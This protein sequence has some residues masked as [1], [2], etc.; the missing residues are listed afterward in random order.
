MKH[1]YVILMT[2]ACRGFAKLRSIQRVTLSI[3]GTSFFLSGFCSGQMNPPPNNLSAEFPSRAG[4]PIPN[5]DLPSQVLA[6]NGQLTLFA[7][8]INCSKDGCPLYL[9]NRT[10][11]D[12]TIPTQDGRLFVKLTCETSSGWE[13]A[14][15]HYFSDCGNSYYPVAL[16]PGQH[17][18]T[19]GYLA[20][21]GNLGKVRYQFHAGPG[22]VS[23]TG[24]G[25]W[26][27]E[28]RVISNADQLAVSGGREL[29]LLSAEKIAGDGADPWESVENSIA[30]LD[31]VSQW[32]AQDFLHDQLRKV[33]ESTERLAA[34]DPEKGKRSLAKIEE[35]SKRRPKP[36]AP[37]DVLRKACIDSIKSN[38]Q[39]DKSSG[40]A[41]GRPWIAW[42]VLRWLIGVEI[43]EKT[44]FIP[45]WKDA[46]N[47]AVERL[48]LAGWR[49]KSAIAELFQNSPL[50]AEHVR[51][52]VLVTNAKSEAYWLS[53]A[54]IAQLAY[55]RAYQKMAGIGLGA[56]PAL[57]LRILARF[58]VEPGATD[59]PRRLR[60]SI[61]DPTEKKFWE[62]CVQA[63]PWGSTFVMNSAT[64]FNERLYLEPWLS[65]LLRDALIEL[66]GAAEKGPF[67]AMSL[68]QLAGVRA[69]MKIMM[70]DPGAPSIALLKRVV[71]LK[72]TTYGNDPKE[73][74]K[75]RQE[76]V[77]AAGRELR[78]EEYFR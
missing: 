13:R 38:G 64:G 3:L 60:S 8:F 11:K 52:E 18:R 29:D 68:E 70:R 30:Y 40:S 17:F 4:E 59:I 63:D 37:A 33:K 7:D 44:L 36:A 19:V 48:P 47:L 61:Y 78:M 20:K 35:I 6:E 2:N 26:S 71:Q 5:V 15:S 69:Y 49:E 56:D 57:R 34:T 65:L 53:E 22:V 16:S 41:A 73:N 77:Q 67:P 66:I 55:R 54:C 10:E 42:Y 32:R 9:V 62:S 74:A 24:A 27:E 12:I 1:Y 75:G 43:S 58:C 45:A 39:G 21:S 23:N 50:M 14:Q 25:Y 72:N 51:T 76:V 28:D 46:F 31:L